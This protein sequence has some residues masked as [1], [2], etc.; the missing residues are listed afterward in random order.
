MNLNPTNLKEKRP[1]SKDRKNRKPSM[2]YDRVLEF[3]N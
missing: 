3:M 1:K 2:K